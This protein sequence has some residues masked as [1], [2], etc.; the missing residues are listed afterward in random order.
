[1]LAYLLV[2]RSVITR[3]FLE[4]P[5][6]FFSFS[7]RC[8]S[9]HDEPSRAYGESEDGKAC[10]AHDDSCYGYKMSILSTVGVEHGHGCRYRY[11]NVHR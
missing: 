1:V 11:Q 10:K 4:N 6:V 9:G 7:M 5:G 8:G 2:M 3:L